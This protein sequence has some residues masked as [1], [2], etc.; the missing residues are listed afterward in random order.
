MI[1]ES[2]FIL[3]HDC[4]VDNTIVIEMTLIERTDGFIESVTELELVKIG[5]DFSIVSLT[6]I[7]STSSNLKPPNLPA[8]TGTAPLG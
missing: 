1:N 7:F 3:R 5:R 6:D 4:N 2:L 8:G